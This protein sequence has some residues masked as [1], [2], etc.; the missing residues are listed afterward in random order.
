MFCSIKE[1]LQK[2][3]GGYLSLH[4]TTRSQIFMLLKLLSCFRAR[5]LMAAWQNRW[6]LLWKKNGINPFLPIEQ[7]ANT[8]S[9]IPL[10]EDWHLCWQPNSEWLET[11]NCVARRK[12]SLPKTRWRFWIQFPV[13]F[14]TITKERVCKTTDAR[15]NNTLQ[16]HT[17]TERCFVLIGDWCHWTIM[18]MW[19]DSVRVWTLFPF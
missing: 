5:S 13:F 6:Y 8:Q 3:T 4:E 7:T 11:K 2:H 19:S 10:T 16:I 17:A 9:C 15:I 14:P 12:R 1:C 18:L